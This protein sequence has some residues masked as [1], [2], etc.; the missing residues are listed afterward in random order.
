M[1]KS[2]QKRKQAPNRL[3][4]PLL[5]LIALILAVGIATLT[6]LLLNPASPADI[7]FLRVNE[8][9]ATNIYSLDI[10]NPNAEV[11]QLTPYEADFT[12]DDFAISEISASALFLYR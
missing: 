4:R 7:I 6:Y 2:K 9:G 8:N 10:D 12:V 11:R 1:A 3:Q 5:V